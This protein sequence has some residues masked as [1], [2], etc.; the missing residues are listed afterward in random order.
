MPDRPS[1]VKKK[2][3]DLYRKKEDTRH[4]LIEIHHMLTNTGFFANPDRYQQPQPAFVPQQPVAPPPPP[5]PV[6]LQ[7]TPPVTA[8]PPQVQRAYT[9]PVNTPPSPQWNPSPQKP[10]APPK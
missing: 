10:P 5:P 1:D 7:V 8:P 6:V 4:N 2:L 9:P 3:D